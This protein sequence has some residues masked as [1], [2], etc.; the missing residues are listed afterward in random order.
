MKK[1]MKT[2]EQLVEELSILRCEMAELKRPHTGRKRAEEAIKQA[3][4]LL[5]STIWRNR[6]ARLK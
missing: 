1:Q 4:S 2:K 6:S 5:T 3:V